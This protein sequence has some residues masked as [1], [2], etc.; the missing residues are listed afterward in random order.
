MMLLSLGI[1]I[2]FQLI[3]SDFYKITHRSFESQLHLLQ[4]SITA[5]FFERYGDVQAFANNRVVQE[6]DKE[7]LE[8]TLNQWV[9]LYGIYDLIIVTDI[10]GNL[11][12]SSSLDYQGRQIKHLDKLPKNFSQELWFKNAI[13]E[14]FTNDHKNKITGSFVEDPAYDSIVS[15]AFGQESFGSGFSTIIKNA[16]GEKV[17]VIS[18]RASHRWFSQEFVNVFQSIKSER[19]TNAEFALIDKNGLLLFDYDPMGRKNN[20]VV[21]DLSVFGKL[22]LVEA[23]VESA[24]RVVKGM[25]G[26]TISKHS[27]KKIDKLT[28]YTPIKGN[29]MTEN[30][31]WSVLM[32]DDIDLVYSDIL[33]GQKEFYLF[34][35]ICIL[36]LTLVSFYIFKKLSLNLEKINHGIETSDKV[37]KKEVQEI[38]R[39]LDHLLRDISKSVTAVEQTAVAST[40]IKE[41]SESASRFA[42]ESYRE[43][44]VMLKLSEEGGTTVQKLTTSMDEIR[45]SN[46]QMLNQVESNN[47]ELEK[48]LAL[49]EEIGT[50]TKVIDEIVFQT[51][52]LSFNASVEAA[53]AG[54]SGKGFAVVADEVGKLASL[55]GRQSQEI[56]E[57]LRSRIEMIKIIIINNKSNTQKII[58]ESK[59]K[60][61][62]GEKS[63]K[64]CEV[65]FEKIYR[66]C[67]AVLDKSHSILKSEEE[68]QTGIVQIANAMSM[69][70]NSILE[71][72]QIAEKSHHSSMIILKHLNDLEGELHQ[73]DHI[74]RGAS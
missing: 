14:K 56:A 53:R 54:E 67:E 57:L 28:A 42:K 11:V 61:S 25:S 30:L 9:R 72:S 71:T 60:L 27:R 23:K 70:E 31:G 35:V 32:S 15:L 1:A 39:E 13:N 29:K 52:L 45:L 18:N 5:Q 51:K 6:L 37:V 58:D 4:Y 24:I 59:T 48:I 69:L 55:S 2:I 26:F 21:T 49:I 19:P 36:T 66:Q 62:Q 33:K 46:D 64:D 20:E 47:G 44:E 63:S 16:K 65:I 3:I 12:K 38:G 41:V 8:G 73:L 34:F 50:K 68:Q 7:N 17:G 74:V 10:N 22:N 40:Q 43:S